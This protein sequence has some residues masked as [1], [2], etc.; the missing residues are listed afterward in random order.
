[1]IRDSVEGGAQGP[2][3]MVRIDRGEGRSV[4]RRGPA[5]GK[6]KKERREAARRMK[7]V[8]TE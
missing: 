6:G 8:E 3:W 7:R 1:M 4:A 2:W 5:E